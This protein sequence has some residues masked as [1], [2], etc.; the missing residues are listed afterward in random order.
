MLKR[1]LNI[2]II[3]MGLLINSNQLM[4]EKMT[5]ELHSLEEL[6]WQNRLLLIRVTS[7]DSLKA[8]LQSQT[9]AIDDRR[10]AW[11]VVDSKQLL[12][13][14][15]SVKLTSTLQKEISGILNSYGDSVA[16]LIGY[17]GEIKAV[18]GKLN[19]VD[20]FDAID[21]MPIRKMEMAR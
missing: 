16:L 2:L 18:Q 3:T 20:F 11:F 21:E 12:R 14:N 6:L 15:L 19:L 13:T 4:A 8:D 10:I 1:L 5:K 7:F 9:E 17:D